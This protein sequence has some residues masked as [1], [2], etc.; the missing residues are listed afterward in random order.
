MYYLRRLQVSSARLF[1]L[2]LLAFSLVGCMRNVDVDSEWEEGVAHDQSFRQ[3]LVIGQSPNVSGRCDF[4][5]FMATQL[6]SDSVN[7]ESSCNLMATTEELTRENIER[8]VD[9][10]RADAV[11]VTVLVHSEAGTEVGG[12]SDTRGGLD[13]KAEGVGYESP[14]YGGY[15]VYGVPVVYGEFKEA[16]VITSVEGEISIRTMLYATSDA[17]LVYELTTTAEDLHSRDQ[18]LATITEPIADRLRGDGL[19]R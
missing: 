4:E 19:I 8:V 11:L 13:F 6:R 9:E 3:L 18:A 15:G 2:L 5:S 16:P 17:T 10:Y 14:Y 7:A 1:M 12:D